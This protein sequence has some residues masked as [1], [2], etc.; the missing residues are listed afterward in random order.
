MQDII[1]L[2]GDHL[3]RMDYMK[4]VDEHRASDA[5]VSIGCLPCAAEQ[6]SAFGLMKIDD[7]ANVTEFAEKP[8]D[9]ALEAMK[10][11]SI[12]TPLDYCVFQ[13]MASEL[14]TRGRGLLVSLSVWQHPTTCAYRTRYIETEFDARWVVF[15]P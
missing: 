5:D 6:A 11:R 12:A 2:S 4:F 7:D 13:Q 1:I 15:V 3:Y 9:E 10:V 8:K 14:S